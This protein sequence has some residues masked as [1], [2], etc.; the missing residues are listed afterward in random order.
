[1]RDCVFTHAL[2]LTNKDTTH[3]V[4][5]SCMHDMISSCMIPSDRDRD[6]DR[7]R[8]LDLSYSA[9]PRVKKQSPSLL[10]GS[11]REATPVSPCIALEL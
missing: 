5:I 4:P 11:L 7:D 8:D 2:C 9:S 6:R 1:M 3:C 10:H